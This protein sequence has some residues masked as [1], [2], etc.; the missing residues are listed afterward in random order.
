LPTR[1]QAAFHLQAQLLGKNADDPVQRPVGG[2]GQ[3]GSAC[4]ATQRAPSTM[5]S[6]SS[7]ENIIGGNRNPDRNR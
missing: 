6:S 5:A 3:P 7:V 4:T 1:E 2:G